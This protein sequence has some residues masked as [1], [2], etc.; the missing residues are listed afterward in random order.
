MHRVSFFIERKLE[1][2]LVR[3]Q[4]E[5]GAPK[6]ESIRRAIA[7]Y[8]EEQEALEKREGPRKVKP[9]RRKTTPR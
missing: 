9:R 5:T 1:K 2:G 4:A 6:A 7:R 3:L 8:L